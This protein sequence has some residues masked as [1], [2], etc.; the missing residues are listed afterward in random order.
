M[1]FETAI[2]LLSSLFAN[3]QFVIALCSVLVLLALLVFVRSLTIMFQISADA[4]AAAK[5]I[6]SSDS[7]SNGVFDGAK[8]TPI[9]TTLE[10]EMRDLEVFGQRTYRLPP[11]HDRGGLMNAIFSYGNIRGLDSWPNIFIGI[12][13]FLTFLGLAL[14]LLNASKGAA[15]GDI[16]TV[17]QSVT[18]LL[19]F[20]AVKF[21][22]S[23]VALF[24]SI[25]LAFT[26]RLHRQTMETKLEDLEYLFDR[27]CPILTVERVAAYSVSS[28]FRAQDRKD[29][30]EVLVDA[31]TGST[32]AL[33]TKQ[34]LEQLLEQ[35]LEQT[36]HLQSFNSNLAIQLGEALDN[37]LQP[38]ILHMVDRVETALRDMGGSIGSTNQDA[39]KSLLDSFV[40]EL[41]SATKS[42]SSELQ[43]NMAELAANLGRTSAELS[44]RMASVFSNFE[45][46]G[47]QF[48]H[49][50]GDAS[51]S[52]R[53]QMAL[54][55]ND[56][57]SGLTEALSAIR[58]ATEHSASQSAA[59]LQQM[60][61]GADSFRSSI[62]SGSAALASDLDR[63]A[64][65]VEVVMQRFADSV[66]GLNSLVDRAAQFGETSSRA[67]YERLAQVQAAL[68]ELDNGF[69][70]VTEASVPLS[71][72]AEQVR[73]AIDLMRATE[74]SIQARMNEFTSAANALSSSSNSL[75]TSVSRD[76]N[77]FSEGLNTSTDRLVASVANI[78]N[79]SEGASRRF[80]EVIQATLNEYEKRFGGID[81]E[82]QTALR[83]IIE[84]FSTTYEEIRERVQTVDQQMAQAV[85]RLVAFNETFGDHTEDLVESVEKLTVAVSSAVRR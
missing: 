20:S 82:L 46:T 4:N 47:Q 30:A 25:S 13:L 67:T 70:R 60:S 43:R 65:S 22:T 26:L 16:A 52:F 42:D 71:R 54:A 29:S 51:Q 37:K 55:Q 11:P 62:E 21:T 5:V 74:T 58:V 53:G 38:M 19:E 15:S 49:M 80:S 50:L 7:P 77:R 32:S 66:D 69:R 44:E 31:L 41:R 36:S 1:S 68:G 59:L 79:E 75:T 64:K 56:V 2:S 57:S 35:S 81:K 78:S 85:G 39:L 34:M 12:G 61:S 45:A 17:K 76:V 3:A 27:F 33:Q 73:A 8:R 72:V 83:S 6:R 84:T 48:A 40:D 63:G 10:R 23:L 14:S 24:C 28:T 18:T 9:I